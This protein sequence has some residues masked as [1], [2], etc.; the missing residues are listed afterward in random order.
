MAVG[1][2]STFSLGSLSKKATVHFPRPGCGGGGDG[3]LGC[4]LA[5]FA[6]GKGFFLKKKHERHEEWDE[7]L[8]GDI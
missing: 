6:H 4:H 5:F 3:S 8:S 7:I 2:L 1:H